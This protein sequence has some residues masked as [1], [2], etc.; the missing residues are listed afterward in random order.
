[1]GPYHSNPTQPLLATGAAGYCQFV[2]KLEMAGNGFSESHSFLLL[3]RH[4]ITCPL[5]FS[6]IPLHMHSIGAET[7]TQ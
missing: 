4:T 6:T 3:F 2:R 5:E 1:M 7:E